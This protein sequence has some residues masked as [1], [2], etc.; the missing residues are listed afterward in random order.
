[1][2]CS[3]VYAGSPQM[4]APSHDRDSVN[5]VFGVQ[6]EISQKIAIALKVIL[7]ADEET[8]RA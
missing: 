6:N 4:A 8:A 3:R 7:T 5:D 1:V 2:P